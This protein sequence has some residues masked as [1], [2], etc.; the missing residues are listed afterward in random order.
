VVLIRFET[1]IIGGNLDRREVRVDGY[2]AG[3][4]I[5]RDDGGLAGG[6]PGG[7]RRGGWGILGHNDLS[8]QYEVEKQKILGVRAS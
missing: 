8:A 4:R 3:G 2:F 7:G 6:F 5:K 1:E